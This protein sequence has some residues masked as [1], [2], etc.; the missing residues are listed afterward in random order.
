MIMQKDCKEIYMNLQ[1]SGK[2]SIS[3]L[4]V[5]NT[6]LNPPAVTP[7]VTD[8]PAPAPAD[9]RVFTLHG[10]VNYAAKNPFSNGSE[11]VSP[12]GIP[13]QIN[14]RTDADGLFMIEELP[15]QKELSFVVH[16]DKNVFV[17]SGVV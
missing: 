13:T 8:T 9:E 12:D 1:C 14:V 2:T 6:P 16:N 4:D 10:K 5:S 11:S 15:T 17:C 3:I 7:T